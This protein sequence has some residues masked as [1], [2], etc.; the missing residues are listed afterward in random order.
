MRRLFSSILFRSTDQFSFRT[1]LISGMLFVP[2]SA[3]G[4]DFIVRTASPP[5]FS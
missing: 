2:L 4:S 5:L 1:R 3:E